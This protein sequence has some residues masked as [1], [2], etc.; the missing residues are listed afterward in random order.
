MLLG[1][2]ASVW[3]LAASAES[4]EKRPAAFGSGRVVVVPVNLG[5][6][7]VAEVGPGIEPV[8]RAL[9][10]YFASEEHPAI[11]LDR[12]D[13]GA[14]WNEV[15]ADA[16]KAGE[17]GDLYAT[18]GRFARRV[19]EQA[20]FDSIVFPTIVT[21]TAHLSG[22]VASWD[23]VRRQIEIPGQFNESIDTYREGRIWLSRHGASGELAATSLH[24]AV[25][26]PK[27]ELRYQGRGGLVLLQE[28]VGPQKPSDG[29]ELTAVM[30]KDPFAAPDQLREGIGAAFRDW[31]N[32]TA[33]IAH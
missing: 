29:M 12:A 15:M 26:S 31:P 14:L 28:L 3:W 17:E 33:S 2:G 8:W 6:R 7:A 19:S 25:L 13:A 16:K 24:I 23:G 1:L 4:G 21:H 18:Y 10:D 5:V 22:R 11:A 30:R 20:E 27:G 32:A 9:L